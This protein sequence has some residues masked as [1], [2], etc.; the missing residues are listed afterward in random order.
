MRLVVVVV[1]VAS[2]SLLVKPDKLVSDQTSG[3]LYNGGVAM[4][5]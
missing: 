3:G 2:L 5:G 4:V 1:K